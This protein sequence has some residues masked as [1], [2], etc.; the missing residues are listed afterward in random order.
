MENDNNSAQRLRQKV[1]ANLLT[2]HQNGQSLR[3][4]EGSQR[5][6]DFAIEN[7]ND[8]N[9]DDVVC[10]ICLDNVEESQQDVHGICAHA[11]HYDCLMEWMMSSHDDCPTCREGLW[12]TNTYDVIEGQIKEFEV[13]EEQQRIEQETLTLQRYIGLRQQ[14]F[15]RARL[16]GKSKRR[17]RNCRDLMRLLF[18]LVALAV[19]LTILVSAN[20]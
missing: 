17:R 9:D 4:D 10:V 6:H 18:V 14:Q 20:K 2:K 5:Y 11:Y 19:L 8:S 16:A 12:E 7:S 3:Y 1:L 13:L 15:D